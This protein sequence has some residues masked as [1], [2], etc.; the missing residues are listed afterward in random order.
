MNRF[1]MLPE[2]LRPWDG[3]Q[4]LRIPPMGHRWDKEGKLRPLARSEGG[5]R[6]YARAVSWPCGART[7]PGTASRGRCGTA[8]RDSSGGVSGSVG[9][10]V[11]TSDQEPEDA[12]SELVKDMLATVTNSSAKRYGMRGGRKA[13]TAVRAAP[14]EAGA[15]GG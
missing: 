1:G 13:R 11:V 2:V 12:A 3:A 14:E 6:R 7:P 15:V 5:H 9:R 8:S 4:A 10:I